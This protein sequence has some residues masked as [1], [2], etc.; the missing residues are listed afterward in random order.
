[1]R[2]LRARWAAIVGVVLWCIAF[3]PAALKGQSSSAQQSGPAPTVNAQ[4]MAALAEHSYRVSN[5]AP[6]RVPNHPP[7][8]QVPPKPMPDNPVW[9]GAAAANSS[10]GQGV[11]Y[12][13]ATRQEVLAPL[14]FKAA[15]GA[16][17]AGGGYN[18]ADG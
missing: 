16:F 9:T 6:A 10:P 4:E 18:G 5:D 12:N 14:D 1:M 13:P 7:I 15:S 3:A 2:I 8:S 17:Q 11:M